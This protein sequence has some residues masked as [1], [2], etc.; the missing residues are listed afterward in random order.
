MVHN[1]GVSLEL[2]NA[3]DASQ[4]TKAHKFMTDLKLQYEAQLSLRCKGVLKEKLLFCANL[5]VA[6]VYAELSSLMQLVSDRLLFSDAFTVSMAFQVLEKCDIQW[7]K[8]QFMTEKEMKTV[9]S[10]LFNEDILKLMRLKIMKWLSLQVTKCVHAHFIKSLKNVIAQMI[11][12]YNALINPKTT[13]D[14]KAKQAL[15]LVIDKANRFA[16]RG[17]FFAQK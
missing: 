7:N 3:N 15:D 10:R 9:D 8:L 13:N 12:E 5:S 11:K 17:E 1:Y 6:A 16:M 4:D 14:P 2:K